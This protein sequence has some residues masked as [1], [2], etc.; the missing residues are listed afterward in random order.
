MVFYTAIYRDHRPMV[1]QFSNIQIDS[2][3]FEL[4]RDG[5]VIPVEPRVLDLLLCFMANPKTLLSHEQLI[6]LVWKGR[7]VSDASIASAVKH[8]RKVLGDSGRAQTF[9]KTVHGRGFIFQPPS[10]DKLVSGNR[11]KPARQEIGTEPYV[12]KIL[13]APFSHGNGQSALGSV[14]EGVQGDLEAMLT[15]V[16]LLKIQ[17]SAS[18]IESMTR[19]SSM[20]LCHQ[21]GVHYLLEGNARRV[22]DG[23][24]LNVSLIDAPSDSLLWAQPFETGLDDN[25]NPQADI[26]VMILAKL[27]PQL[28]KAMLVQSHADTENP[29][30]AALYIK[31]SGILALKGW[32]RQTFE[33]A[34]S[35]L[36]QCLAQD[37]DF[38]LA[39]SYLALVLSL[40]H[41][42]GLFPNPESIKREALHAA[43]SAMRKDSTDSVLLGYAGCALADLG[44]LDRAKPILH[45]A[46]DISSANAQAWAALGS[47]YLMQSQ[48]DEAVRYLRKSIEISPLDSRLSVWGAVLAF[49]LLMN[50]E[51]DEAQKQAEWACR[52]DDRIYFPWVVLSVIATAQGNA[53]RAHNALAEAYRIK[54]DL[55]RHEINCLVGKKMGAQLWLQAEALLP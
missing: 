40:G 48:L 34:S 51:Y 55:S 41:R 5:D 20:E 27:E 21:R 46:I 13:I 3:R 24:R 44:F 23:V 31:A 16:P 22:A 9:I 4:R 50:D 43:E 15:R 28:V 25:G 53:A 37:P 8:A 30:P 45:K 54:P 39:E 32:H 7:C 52:H 1:Y 14:I 35:L 26:A 42:F 10:E 11:V 17:P 2:L 33:E 36:K 49:A 38:A 19:L 6:E 47:V 12:P 29:T 18:L